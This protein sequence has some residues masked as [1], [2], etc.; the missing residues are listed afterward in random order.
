MNKEIII[1]EMHELEV[2]LKYEFNDIEWLAKAMESILIKKTSSK[3]Q[4]SN[5]SLAFVGDAILKLVISDKLYRNDNVIIKG[6]LTDAK[7]LLENNT[8][9]KNLIIGEHII[10]YT[11]NDKHF[12]KDADIPGH[13]R[14]I[15]NNHP[16]CLEAIVAAIFYDSDFYKTQ[17]W[18]IRWLLPLLEKYKNKSS[19]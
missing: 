4:Y 2:I 3:K 16:A 14:V 7:K 18:I 10:D 13:E 19:N 5:D 6:E 12:H 8:T 15:D 11:Y 17:E 1:K 9:M